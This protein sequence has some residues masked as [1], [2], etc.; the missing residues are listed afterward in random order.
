MRFLT[1]RELVVAVS[2]DAR[3]KENPQGDWK[4][5]YCKK[6]YTDDDGE[7][8]MVFHPKDNPETGICS[9]CIEELHIA[10]QARI[11]FKQFVDL[12]DEWAEDAT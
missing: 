7:S 11:W 10:H 12:A 9:N 4:C 2:I 3:F 1:R 5:D 8:H 6:T